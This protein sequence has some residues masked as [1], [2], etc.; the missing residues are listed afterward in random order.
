MH[1]R[2]PG[3]IHPKKS[4]S[5]DAMLEDVLDFAVLTLVDGARLCMWMPTANEEGNEVD[6]PK[7]PS[8]R[9]EAVSVQAF[10]K[11]MQCKL[12]APPALSKY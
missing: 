7:H 8:L 12:S 6:I 2:L 1:S 11:C 3:F 5:F 4:Y 10:N 9:L